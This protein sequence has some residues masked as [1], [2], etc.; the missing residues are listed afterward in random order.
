M[1]LLTI[2]LLKFSFKQNLHEMSEKHNFA[3]RVLKGIFNLENKIW[4]IEEE[5]QFY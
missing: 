1:H 5:E 4:K 3:G 2:V